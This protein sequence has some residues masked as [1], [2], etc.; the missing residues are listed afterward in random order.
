MLRVRSRK[1]SSVWTVAGGGEGDED[2]N[3]EGDVFIGE[4]GAV[5][6]VCG[7]GSLFSKQERKRGRLL[8][9]L[10][11]IEVDKSSEWLT[12][13]DC[14]KEVDEFADRLDQ[15]KWG[16]ANEFGTTEEDWERENTQFRFLAGK[17]DR[18]SL[19]VRGSLRREWDLKEMVVKRDEEERLRA[20]Q[21]DVEI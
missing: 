4:L 3:Y 19:S 5:A 12:E 13:E 6:E 2:A 9:A 1:T 14:I 21:E 15:W 20:T 17:I 7:A 11:A 10:L 16:E 8:W 18:L